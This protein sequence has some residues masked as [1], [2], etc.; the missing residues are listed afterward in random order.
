MKNHVIFVQQKH[1][2]LWYLIYLLPK[3]RSDFKIILIHCAKLT[4]SAMEGF[5]MFRL[6]AIIRSS[7]SI[8]LIS[9][10]TK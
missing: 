10:K 1:P 4:R 9:N 6:F 5:D 7:S 2:V 3:F 8:L